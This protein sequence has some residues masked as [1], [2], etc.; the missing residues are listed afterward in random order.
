MGERIWRN[1][2]PTVFVLKITTA[3]N[4]KNTIR[5]TVTSPVSNR[6]APNPGFV[7]QIVSFTALHADVANGGGGDFVRDGCVFGDTS[8]GVSR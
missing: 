3:R 8:E 2:I 7:F 4:A 1:E 6:E 5:A